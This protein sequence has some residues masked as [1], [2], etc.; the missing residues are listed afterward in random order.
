MKS[1]RKLKPDVGIFG[2]TPQK[3][4]LKTNTTSKQRKKK[5]L[6]TVNVP[7]PPVKG[8]TSITS[9]PKPS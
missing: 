5:R 6:S 4:A 1:N 8:D 3:K 7:K 9:K 2:V